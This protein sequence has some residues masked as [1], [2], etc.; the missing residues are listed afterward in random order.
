MLPIATADFTNIISKASVIGGQD[1]NGVI[2]DSIL[3]KMDSGTR[4]LQTPS[5]ASTSIFVYYGIKPFASSGLSITKCGADDKL[6]VIMLDRL[7][8]LKFFTP[9]SAIIE[10]DADAFIV[11]CPEL[12]VFGFADDPI[13]AINS[14]KREI[15]S[16]YYELM[17]D[18][19]FSPQW[20]IYKEFLHNKVCE[21][22]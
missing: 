2:V 4:D 10:P 19:N 3:K 11:R 6:Q 7:I 18:D 14:L 16:L 9:I 8:K 5:T 12:P 1:Y 21:P 13:D 22:E 17:E 15:E 20:L